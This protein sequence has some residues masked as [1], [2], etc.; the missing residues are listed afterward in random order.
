MLE[1]LDREFKITLINILRALMEKVDNMQ[2]KMGNESR[3]RETLRKNKKEMVE[4]KATLTEMKNALMGS[5][6]DWTCQELYT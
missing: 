4:I 3:E 5:V 2:E 6:A 1:L